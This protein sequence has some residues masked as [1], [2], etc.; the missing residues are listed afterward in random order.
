LIIF[1][2]VIT[3]KKINLPT[4]NLPGMTVKFFYQSLAQLSKTALLISFQSVTGSPRLTLAFKMQSSLSKQQY[5]PALL[6]NETGG[7]VPK[8]VRYNSMPL[9]PGELSRL[10]ENSS[11]ESCGIFDLRFIAPT[12]RR[13]S[14]AIFPKPCH[15]G[16]WLV[17]SATF[18]R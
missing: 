8:A 16:G 12:A 7:W 18:V 17:L 9:G 3:H 10:I 14:V 13:A 4:K 11:I 1:D 2:G 5:F 15:Q 6:I